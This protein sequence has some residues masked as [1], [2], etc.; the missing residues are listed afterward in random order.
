LKEARVA[1]R[2]PAADI[3][4]SEVRESDAGG[5]RRQARRDQDRL[6]HPGGARRK[7]DVQADAGEKEGVPD[8]T[9]ADGR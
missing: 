2:E 8:R 4:A 6:G 9:A 1:A 3:R 7:H 5:R